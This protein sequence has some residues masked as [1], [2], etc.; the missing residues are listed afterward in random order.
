MGTT[1]K[2]IYR[3]SAQ[4][5]WRVSAEINGALVDFY[6][7]NVVL[8]GV[9]PEVEVILPTGPHG[10]SSQ[11]AALIG[12]SVSPKKAMKV[13]LFFRKNETWWGPNASLPDGMPSPFESGKST[14]DLPV[15]QIWYYDRETLMV[16]N[17]GQYSSQVR[18]GFLQDPQAELH[19]LFAEIQEVH[20]FPLPEPL[21]DRTEKHFWATALGYWRKALNVSQAF[22][23]IADG[24]ADG[25][26]IYVAGDYFSHYQGW[27]EGAFETADFVCSKLL[28]RSSQIIMV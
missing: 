1:V 10:V 25:S 5:L 8:T 27:T 21:W 23:S 13:F 11:R 17:N 7:K 9:G 15:R 4:G 19:E 24:R 2:K 28:S 12:R 18:D 6:A 22:E 16:Y 14:T 3:G 26:N 20:G